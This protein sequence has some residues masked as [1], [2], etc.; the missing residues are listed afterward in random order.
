M[1][2]LQTMGGCLHEMT[3]SHGLS[4][5]LFLA[6]IVGGFTHCVAMCGPFVISQSKSMSRLQENLLLPY[7]LGRLTTYTL[8][9]VLLSSVLNIVFLYLPLRAVLIAPLLMLAG[10]LFIVSAFPKISQMFSW[11]ASFKISVPYAWVNSLFQKLSN[12]KQG[13]TKTFA[14]GL[15]LGLLPCGLVTSAL[16]AATTAATP[17]ESGFAMASFGAG[18]LPALMLTAFAGQ[19]IQTKYP[20][21]MPY[22]TKGMLV[23]SGAWLF[24]IAG[25]MLT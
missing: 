6:G 21:V 20:K 9:A 18:T 15:V 14:M 24:I 12:G 23:W 16:L 3:L 10:L 5:S 17:W 1:T 13:F 7:H 25:L 19:A 2:F 8:L 11:V 4:V 22:M